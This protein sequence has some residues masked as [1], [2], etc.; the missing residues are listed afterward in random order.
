MTAD[1]LPHSPTHARA[2]AWTVM[3]SHAHMQHV[4][5]CDAHNLIFA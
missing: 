2:Y 1:H 3:G 5:K 4:K